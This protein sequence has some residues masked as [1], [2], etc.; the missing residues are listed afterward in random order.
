MELPL[1]PSDVDMGLG[2]WNPNSQEESHEALEH[3]KDAIKKLPEYKAVLFGTSGVGKS[4]L[5]DHPDDP[6]VLLGGP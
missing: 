3:S 5:T 6:P 2:T 4:A 1:P